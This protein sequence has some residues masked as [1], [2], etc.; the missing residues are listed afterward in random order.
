MN[1]SGENLEPKTHV[2]KIETQITQTSS[3]AKNQKMSL[4]N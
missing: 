2:D 3:A 1:N 4:D